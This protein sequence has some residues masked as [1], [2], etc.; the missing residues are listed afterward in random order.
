MKENATTENSIYYDK[1]YF[2]LNIVCCNS[3]VFLKVS[4]TNISQ[5][6]VQQIQIQNEREIV[7]SE[8]MLCFLPKT[9][10]LSEFVP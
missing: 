2:L 5:K 7:K 8:R 10:F 1:M 9:I 6:A 3:T 4:L